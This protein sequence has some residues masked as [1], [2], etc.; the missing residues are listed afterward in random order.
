MEGSQGEGGI[1]GGIQGGGMSEEEGGC[2]SMEEREI[3]R[4]GGREAEMEQG[5]E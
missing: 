5:Q 4:E 3:G 2:V 1:D